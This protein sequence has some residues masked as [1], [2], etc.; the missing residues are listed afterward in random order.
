MFGKSMKKFKDL[1]P[2][3]RV[4]ILWSIMFALLNAVA[5][6]WN[7]AMAWAFILYLQVRL[8]LPTKE[9]FEERKARVLKEPDKK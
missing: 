9:E 1:P 8:Y 3:E 7:A 4:Y 5:G 6:E 2:M